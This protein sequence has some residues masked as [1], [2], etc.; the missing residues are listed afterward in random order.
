MTTHSK[1]IENYKRKFNITSLCTFNNV[2]LG[3]KVKWKE[4]IKKRG[5]CPLFYFRKITL[6]YINI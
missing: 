2:L 4:E 5:Q 3:A 1:F 6:F